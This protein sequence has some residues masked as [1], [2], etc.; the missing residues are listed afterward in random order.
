MPPV[1]LRVPK[2]RDDNNI[3]WRV[4]VLLVSVRLK[5][6]EESVGAKLICCIKGLMLIPPV[7]LVLFAAEECP[8]TNS[9]LAAKADTVINI[10]LLS[11]TDFTYPALGFLNRGF[12]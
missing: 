4:G 5:V 7:A 11:T 2:S 8:A 6:F 12:R 9:R 10:L 3:S 1:S